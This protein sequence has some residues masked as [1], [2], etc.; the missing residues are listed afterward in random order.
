M[1]TRRNK[2]LYSIWKT[3][4]QRCLNPKSTNFHKYGARG[5]TVC[6]EW[7]SFISF[8][9]WAYLNGYAQNLTLDRIDNDGDYEPANCRWA[10]YIEQ[11]NNRR[12]NKRITFQD[13]TMTISE[14]ARYLGMSVT[15]LWS[16]LYEYNWSIEKALTT[17]RRRYASQKL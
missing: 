6:E 14:W 9:D 16:R 5:I 15:T 8:Q 7:D 11:N 17:S 1:E 4:R 13:Q 12:D 10:T 2:R 3:M